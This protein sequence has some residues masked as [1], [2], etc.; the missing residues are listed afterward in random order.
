MLSLVW[1][2]TELDSIKSYYHYLLGEIP[3]KLLLEPSADYFKN[4]CL[5]ELRKN[6]IEVDLRV[7]GNDIEFPFL[8]SYFPPIWQHSCPENML[9]LENLL[10]QLLMNLFVNLESRASF[11][12]DFPKIISNEEMPQSNDRVLSVKATFW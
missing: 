12:A 5:L 7:P 1:L 11:P 8:P 9:Q 3:N 2:Q 6:A 4:P 10:S